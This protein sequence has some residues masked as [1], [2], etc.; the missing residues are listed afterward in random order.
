MRLIRLIRG[1]ILATALVLLTAPAAQAA[2]RYAANTGTGPAGSCPQSNP[3]GIQAAIEDASVMTGDTIIVLPG[4][5]NLG[6]NGL[7]PGPAVTIQGMSP[8]Q[9]PRL[10]GDFTSIASTSED[11][12]S[13]LAS[14]S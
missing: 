12:I 14:G 5:Y 7:D 9:R 3:C 2:T 8:S 13:L 4:D 10:I 6:S 11:V 1:L